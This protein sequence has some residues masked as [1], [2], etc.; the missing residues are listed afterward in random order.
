VK[1]QRAEVA[2]AVI[3][4]RQGSDALTPTAAHA[5]VESRTASL[6]ILQLDR[7]LAP[8]CRDGCVADLDGRH[9]STRELQTQE[10]AEPTWVTDIH[11]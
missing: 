1:C 6:V 3:A 9:G 8:V 7:V 2:R 4:L 11:A 10:L 5:A